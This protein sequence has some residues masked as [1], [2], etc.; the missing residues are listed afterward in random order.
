[1]QHKDL[2]L[3]KWEKLTLVEQLANIGSEVERTIKW[4]EKGNKDYSQQAFYR[5]LEL[6]DLTLQTPL[7]YH[8]LKEIAR[9]REALVDFFVGDNIYKSTSESWKKY[10]FAFNYAARKTL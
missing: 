5:A 1:M 6:I 10:F 4:R 7:A 9:V 3:D 2:D 8:R